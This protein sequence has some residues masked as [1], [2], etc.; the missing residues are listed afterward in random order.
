M[1][2]STRDRYDI[3]HSFAYHSLVRDIPYRNV[4]S[5]RARNLSS[6]QANIA[7]WCMLSTGTKNDPNKHAMMNLHACELAT[8]AWLEWN[9]D[10]KLR[11][12]H[13]STRSHKRLVRAKFVLSSRRVCGEFVASSWR[14][15]SEFVKVGL[16]EL[17]ARSLHASTMHLLACMLA[18]ARSYKNAVDDLACLQ[19]VHGTGVDPH[20]VM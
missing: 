17:V 15:R 10:D 13:A 3:T 19:M 7:S 6:R 2:L 12:L 9:Y 8:M 18:E 16:Y 4:S 14:V 1:G 20:M 5:R 11:S